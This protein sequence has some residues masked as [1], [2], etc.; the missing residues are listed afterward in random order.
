MFIET[1]KLEDSLSSPDALTASQVTSLIEEVLSSRA[2]LIGIAEPG[3]S[4]AF[5]T[6]ELASRYQHIIMAATKHLVQHCPQSGLTDY[7][8]KQ[9]ERAIND[10]RTGFS[11]TVLTK[12]SPSDTKK[13]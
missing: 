1:K 7:D 2:T 12:P 4:Y 6:A 5:T 13:S 10:T 3:S 11:Y 9:W 8:V